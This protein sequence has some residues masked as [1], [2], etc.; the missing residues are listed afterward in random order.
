MAVPGSGLAVVVA[1]VRGKPATMR[2]SRNRVAKHGK[3]GREGQ[4]E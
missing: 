1:A 4:G 2:Q 3:R